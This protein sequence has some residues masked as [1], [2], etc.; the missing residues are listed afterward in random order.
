MSPASFAVA[1]QKLGVMIVPFVHD[2]IRAVTHVDVRRDQL[3]HVLDMVKQVLQAS[4]TG[5][6]HANGVK[7]PYGDW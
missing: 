7:S 3:Q 1:L 2:T 4:N 6:G 5:N